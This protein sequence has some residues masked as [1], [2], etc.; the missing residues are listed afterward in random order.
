VISL[1]LIEFEDLVV[2]NFVAVEFLVAVERVFVLPAFAHEELAELLAGG[3]GVF[4]VSYVGD[5]F[6]LYELYLDDFMFG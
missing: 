2:G 6:F 4:V 3:D 5:L 1:R